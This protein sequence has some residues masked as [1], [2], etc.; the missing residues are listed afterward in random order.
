MAR[1]PDLPASAGDAG[2][3]VGPAHPRARLIPGAGGILSAHA[4]ARLAFDSHRHRCPTR[5]DIGYSRGA[6]LE[7]SHRVSFRDLY[8]KVSQVRSARAPPD[9]RFHQPDQIIWQTAGDRASAARQPLH[10][11]AGDLA[12]RSKHKNSARYARGLG[13]ALTG[14]SII[15][16]SASPHRRQPLI[17]RRA[18][19]RRNAGLVANWLGDGRRRSCAY[20]YRCRTRRRLGPSSLPR[21]RIPARA[22]FT[23]GRQR[24]LQF[25][26]FHQSAR[27]DCSIHGIITKHGRAKVA[28]NDSPT[29]KTATSETLE[30]KGGVAL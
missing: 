25:S 13:V 17:H 18:T 3:G 8:E 2:A 22:A 20:L 10:P 24:S 28:R 19:R 9:R 14:A 27:R 16:A 1:R 30:P 4:A 15:N 26:P 6:A 7:A 21:P 29:I 5:D 23:G 12:P 11:S